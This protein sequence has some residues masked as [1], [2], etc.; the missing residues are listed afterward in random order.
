MS[1]ANLQLPA[2]FS[3]KLTGKWM[4]PFQIVQ[5][6]SPVSFT[7]ELPAEYGKLHPTFHASMLEPHFGELPMRRQPVPVQSAAELEYEVE[8]IL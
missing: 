6:I 4:G 8:R 3:R 5:Q 1:T 2:G 7:V